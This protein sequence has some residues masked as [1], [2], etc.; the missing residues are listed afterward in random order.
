MFGS[1]IVHSS[2]LYHVLSLSFVTVLN[3]LIYFC[4]RS[5]IMINNLKTKK[6]YTY[7]HKIY[8]TL[9]T[10]IYPM[11]INTLTITFVSETSS[12]FNLGI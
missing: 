5:Y 3:V 6:T 9:H 11:Y 4:N 8:N 2:K 7:T 10:Y 1:I 12:K